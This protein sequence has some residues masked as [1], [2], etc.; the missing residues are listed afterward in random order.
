MDPPDP[1]S[2]LY[3]TAELDTS[4]KMRGLRVQYPGF[5]LWTHNRNHI[6]AT[7]NHA[8]PKFWFP[9][10]PSFLDWYVVEPAD[11]PGE[12]ITSRS[13]IPGIQSSENS[14]AII[15]S[16]P[17]PA[18]TPA[19]IGLL[20]QIYEKQSDESRAENNTT[21]DIN[22]DFSSLDNDTIFCCEIIHR[23]KVA[24]ETGGDFYAANRG[25]VFRDFKESEYPFE[26]QAR[27]D[28][29]E[30]MVDTDADGQIC[31][32]EALPSSQVWYVDGFFRGGN[33]QQTTS[34]VASPPSVETTQRLLFPNLG[35]SMRAGGRRS[36]VSPPATGG[37]GSQAPRRETIGA[38]I[39][40][41]DTPPEGVT[42][43]HSFTRVGTDVGRRIRRG[44]TGLRRIRRD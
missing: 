14:L 30:V 32:A 42:G 12:E 25:R 39:V 40:Q 26:P 8:N 4:D 23:V 34:K 29:P 5:L 15:L 38:V 13:F 27:F 36:G 28:P 43:R 44:W 22:R 7:D 3:S 17:R 41:A 9:S 35:S 31:L 19:E 24:R 1:L 18:N 6:L 10:D 2:I 21:G 37:T 20:V 16:R 33:P 11:M